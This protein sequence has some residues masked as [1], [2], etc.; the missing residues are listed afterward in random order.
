MSL[1]KGKESFAFEVSVVLSDFLSN[2]KEQKVVAAAEKTGVPG[3]K[4]AVR[5]GGI[6]RATYLSLPL[7]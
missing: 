4:T 1:V 3:E 2:T 5:K 7:A 6:D